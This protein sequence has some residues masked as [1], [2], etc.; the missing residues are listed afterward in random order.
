[1]WRIRV[2]PIIVTLGTLTLIEGVVT[3]ITQGQGVY[4]LHAGF[5]AIGQSSPLGV[6]TEIW[7]TIVLA[8]IAGIILS[9]T[10]IGAHVYA[11]GGN[12]EASELA[13]SS[14]R[15]ITL[16]LFVFSALAAGL[17]GIITSALFGVAD[18]NFGVD[19]NLKVITATILGG[20]TFTGGE[21]TIGGMILAV[22]FLNIVSSGLIAS[23]V[24]PYSSDVIQGHLV[25]SIGLEHLTQERND[26]IRRQI[27]LRS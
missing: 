19:F 13:G 6:P 9:E 22:I 18:I 17:A 12:R 1:M 27:T 23:G 26:R 8:I 10:T 14:V 15:R 11:L 21:G 2:S 5:L 16:G 25:I 4:G 7:V 24:D 3:V 20:I